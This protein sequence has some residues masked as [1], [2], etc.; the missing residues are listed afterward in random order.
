MANGDMSPGDRRWLEG[1]LK[2]IKKTQERH[3][4]TQ[5]KIFGEIA[6]TKAEQAKQAQENTR[7]FGK[8][9]NLLTQMAGE[10]G[11]NKKDIKDVQDRGRA[12]RKW[13]WGLVATL[14]GG[15]AL[16][17]ILLVLGLSS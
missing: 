15:V 10:V 3:S 7:D 8:V 17:V 13:W 6:E 5:I 1:S 2:D 16:T 14:I 9:Q 4:Q 11:A 12:N